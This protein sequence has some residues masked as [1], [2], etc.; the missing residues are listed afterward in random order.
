MPKRDIFDK[1]VNDGDLSIKFSTVGEFNDILLETSRIE[2]EYQRAAADA[3]KA[4]DEAELRLSIV[5]AEVVENIRKQDNIPPSAVSEIRKSRLPLDVRYQKVKKKWIEAKHRAAVFKGLTYTW[6]HRSQR[7]REISIL[8][9][10]LM[11]G[12]ELMYKDD[13]SY[14]D[15][16]DLPA[17]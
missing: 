16:L 5:T 9:N 1:A 10:K 2:A 17:R 13:S 15:K 8:V 7:L 6:N 12:N 4:F 3:E 14:G 11:G